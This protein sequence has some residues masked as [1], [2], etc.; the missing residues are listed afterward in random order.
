MEVQLHSD[1]HYNKIRMIKHMRI[2]KYLEEASKK[3]GK[4]K[5]FVHY[6][7]CQKC[8]TNPGNE[9]YCKR[10]TFTSVCTIKRGIRR[11]RLHFDDDFR[12]KHQQL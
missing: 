9:E 12:K 8:R 10:K 11:G 2:E 3:E 5:T 7:K 1:M 4:Q 6:S